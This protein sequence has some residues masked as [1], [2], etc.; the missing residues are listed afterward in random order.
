[1]SI[2]NTISEI[3]WLQGKRTK[4]YY[5]NVMETFILQEMLRKINIKY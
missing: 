1:M 5:Y 2:K 3:L 4:T